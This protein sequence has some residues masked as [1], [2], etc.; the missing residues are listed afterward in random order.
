[1]VELWAVRWERPLTDRE[2][3]ALLSCLPPERRAR[4]PRGE[5]ARQG[6]LCAYGLL[7]C[8]ARARWGWRTLP[9]TALGPRGK[10]FFPDRPELAFNLSHTQGAAL[11]A[12]AQG[13]VGVDIQRVRPARPEIMR[14]LAGTSDPGSFFPIWVR[15][16]ARSKR[17]GD[18]PIAALRT[19]APP[20]AEERYQALAL[21]PGYGAGVSWTAPEALG[22]VHVLTLE[23]LAADPD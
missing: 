12:V 19:E 2:A 16:E 1:M 6:P 13:P 23:E 7:R 5:G 20:E 3:A 22:P 17:A 8:A 18:R 11:A 21:F 15:R 9:E 4:L 14:R 10:P